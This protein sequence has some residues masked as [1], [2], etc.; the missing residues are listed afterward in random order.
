MRIATWNVN[1]LKARQDAVENWLRPR[2]SPTSCSCRRPSSATAT[3]RSWRSRWPATT[4]STTARAAGTASRSRPA[5]PGDRATSSRTSATDRCATAGPGATAAVGEDDF[6]PFDE[7]RMLAATV[8]GPAHRQPLRAQRPR[9]RLAV[10]PGQ[11]RLVRAARALARR[12]APRAGEPL[13]SAATSTSPR[14]T[15]TS[16]TPRPPTAGPTCREPERAAVRALLDWGLSTPTGRGTT[17]PGRFTW[18]DYR[19]GM[20]HKNFGMRIDL[21]LAEPSRGRGSSRP[22]STARRARARRSRRITPR[23]RSTSTSRASRSTRTGTGPSP[24]SRRRTRWRTRWLGRAGPATRAALRRT[25]RRARVPRARR[26][27]GPP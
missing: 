3:R 16:G 12:D 18:W 14:P 21:L 9:R 23:C 4:S 19:A 5:R 22:R 15:S 20:F 10:L 11:A 2:R 1:S 13:S 17:R 8:D 25:G 6:D 26:R 27:L 24:G 7:A